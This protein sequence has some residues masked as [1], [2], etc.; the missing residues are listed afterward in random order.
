MTF[1]CKVKY[2]V[3]VEPLESDQP[4]TIASIRQNADLK[5]TLGFGDNINLYVNGV[6]MPNDAIVPNDATVVIETA[7]NTKATV[8]AAS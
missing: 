7:A 6:A 8:L 1:S 5:H 2:S 3:D 4:I